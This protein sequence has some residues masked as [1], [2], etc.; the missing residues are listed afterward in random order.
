MD[1]IYFTPRLNKTKIKLPNLLRAL[2]PNH[3][4][5]HTSI[6][7][8]FPSLAWHSLVTNSTYSFSAYT[9]IFYSTS[10]STGQLIDI[11]TN[12]FSISYSTPI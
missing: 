7:I 6:I 12:Q 5:L 1:K 9:L 3:Q 8:S 11:V 10:A 4:A 2:L